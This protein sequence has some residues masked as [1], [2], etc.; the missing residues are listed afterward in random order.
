MSKIKH[1]TIIIWLLLVPYIFLYTLILNPQKITSLNNDIQ[2]WVP[3]YNEF[4][5]GIITDHTI[6]M[7]QNKTLLG[8][9][10]L[11]DPQ[12]IVTYPLTYLVTFVS[13]PT[14][15]VLYLL[16]H[17]KLS[18]LTTYFVGKHIIK[19]SRL[20]SLLVSFL[21]TFSPKMLSHIGE[22]H[23]NLVAA[24]SLFPALILCVYMLIKKPDFKKSLLVGLLF[25]SLF[26][27]Y[28]TIFYYSLLAAILLIITLLISRNLHLYIKKVRYLILALVFGLGFQFPQ[29]LAEIELWPQLSRYLLNYQDTG[30]PI[31]AWRQFFSF[32]FN[33]FSI[34]SYPVEYMLYLGF[35][36]VILA[37]IGFFAI[38]P[39]KYK[40]TIALLITIV[41]FYNFGTK[42]NVYEFAY[43]FIPG[44]DLFRVPTRSY[45]LITLSISLLAGLGLKYIKNK[46]GRQIAVLLVLI[47]FFEYFL[48]G[49]KI[50]NS[51]AAVPKVEP[52]NISEVIT[53]DYDS[54]FRVYCTSSCIPYEFIDDKKIGSAVGYNPV[55]LAN[56]FQYHQKMGG[57]QFASYAPFLPPYQTFVDMPQPNA[58]NLGLLRV[59]YVIST[60][61][62]TDPNLKLVS[63]IDNYL[64]YQNLIVLP[65][66]FLIK[67]GKSL[68]LTVIKDLPGQIEVDVPQDG[69]VA[70][71]EVFTLSWK[72]YFNNKRINLQ[73][74][75]NI[76]ISANPSGPGRLLFKYEPLGT[77]FSWTV[78]LLSYTILIVVFIKRIFK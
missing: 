21:Y 24:Y 34:G 75:N 15:F 44:V 35:T 55:Q 54:Y 58:Q 52:D 60:Y 65:R 4:K 46:Y 23:I 38:K 6:P 43:K 36:A 3:I 68:P 25:S 62:L 1:K 59:K 2:F 11:G 41:L 12:S 70:I 71:S 49:Q 29:I 30:G 53:K 56:V 27:T 73:K 5:K 7:W 18:S 39:T 78:P 45:Y 69:E 37:G 22:G 14:F 8:F 10:I 67:N 20:P 76:I 57:Y 50:L 64:L 17:L 66:A 61:S 63:N 26:I 32:I 48:I 28:I 74:Y 51:K 72:A 13:L 33:P 31:Y 40:I 19:L 47:C 16:F 42:T 77:P 9:P